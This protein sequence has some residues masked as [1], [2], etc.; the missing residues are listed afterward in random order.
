MKASKKTIK[1]NLRDAI[2]PIVGEKSNKE[3]DKLVLKSIKKL[4]DLIADFMDKTDKKQ[5]KKK[6]P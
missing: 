1:K 2:Q 5:K 3:I 6:I 4:S